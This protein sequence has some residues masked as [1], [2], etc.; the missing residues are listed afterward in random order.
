MSSTNLIM[1]VING[2]NDNKLRT[3]PMFTLVKTSSFS[4]SYNYSS[5]QNLINERTVSMFSTAVFKH[6]N[7]QI[8]HTTLKT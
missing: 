5:V 1:T 4:S 2:W 6:F 3:L 7:D 8:M